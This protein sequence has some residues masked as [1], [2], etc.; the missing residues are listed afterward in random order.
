MATAGNFQNAYIVAYAGRFKYSGNSSYP[1]YIWTGNTSGNNAFA[2]AIWEG[3]Y[4]DKNTSLEVYALPVTWM[5]V[6]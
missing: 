3:G 6:K 2:H 4:I 5:E 1:S